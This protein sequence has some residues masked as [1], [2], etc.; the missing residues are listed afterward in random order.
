MFYRVI[1]KA[2]SN[3]LF[4]EI[5]R[6]SIAREH[7][8]TSELNRYFFKLDDKFCKVYGAIKIDNSLIVFDY[9]FSNTKA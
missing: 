3:H 8:N 9:Y 7:F 5:S 6:H 4:S 2:K 1:K